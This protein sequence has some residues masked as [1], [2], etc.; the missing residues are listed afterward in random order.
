MRGGGGGWW[1][2]GGGWWVVGGG[3]WVVGGGWVGVALLAAR[4]LALGTIAFSACSGHHR[5]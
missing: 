5:G 3:W 2:V 1:V 4:A